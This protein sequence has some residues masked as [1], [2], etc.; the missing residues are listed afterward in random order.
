M[1]MEAKSHRRSLRALD[2]LNVCMS[3]VQ[4]GVGP[5]LA[6][7]LMVTRH[8]D[9]AHIGLAM[10][11]M[12]LASVVAQTPAG[13]LT[14]RLRQKRWMIAAAAV[15]VAIGCL[16]I[17]TSPALAGVVAAQALIGSTATIFPTAV[18]AITLGLVGPSQL[19]ARM[20]RNGACNHAG[21]VGAAIL[22]GLIGYAIAQVEAALL[23]TRDLTDH[24]LA[25]E[26]SRKTQEE[27]A[28][29]I[30]QPLAAVITNGNTCLRWI[31]RDPP[32]L[33]EAGEAVRRV[34]RDSNR[35]SIAADLGTSDITITLHHG[36]VMHKMWAGSLAELVR[37]AEKLGLP[38][39][40]Y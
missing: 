20:G 38:V 34:I 7:Y 14:D 32:N 25:S 6:I 23:I 35:A 4:T 39:T 30:N 33:E 1:V 29:E 2:W 36:Q 31:S 22:A 17:V 21:T 8:W 27:I 28:H 24:M 11:A 15:M 3:D 37:M 5:Y 19:A 9:P 13:A 10:S 40:R 12:G 26:A 16:W 18:A